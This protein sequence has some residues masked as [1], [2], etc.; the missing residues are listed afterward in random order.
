MRHAHTHR[1]IYIHGYAYIYI[2][3]YSTL[4]THIYIYTY[5]VYIISDAICTHI[6]TTCVHRHVDVHIYTYR[7]TRTRAFFCMSYKGA[8]AIPHLVWELS[9]D[10][11]VVS[12]WICHGLFFDAVTVVRIQDPRPAAL[13]LCEPLAS[14]WQTFPKSA[15][16]KLPEH[17][18]IDRRVW[19]QYRK[20]L[21]TC[22]YISRD[23]KSSGVANVLCSL[24]RQCT[25]FLTPCRS[26][27]MAVANVVTRWHGPEILNG[28]PC[29]RATAQLAAPI[30]C[31]CTCSG[32]ATKRERCCDGRCCHKLERN[33]CFKMFQVTLNRW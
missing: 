9:L 13:Q 5:T 28:R 11:E 3:S 31:L 22:G 17:T 15:T 18:K 26:M 24:C 8:N 10:I 30:C 4:R 21:A 33:H 29:A 2:H 23:I 20:I 12:E 6:H 1:Y 19:K 7:Q 16:S 27:K 25:C 14:T 32:G